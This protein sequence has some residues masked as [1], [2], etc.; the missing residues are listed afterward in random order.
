MA[1]DGLGTDAPAHADDSSVVDAASQEGIHDYFV[2]RDGQRFAGVHLLID[3]WGASGLDDAVLVER[4][5]SDA[6]AAAGATVLHVHLK[7]F[8]ENG[9]VSGVLVLAESHIS[10]H[11][12]PERGFA[13]IDIFTCGNCVPENAVPVFERAFTP[14]RVTVKEERRGVDG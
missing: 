6:A 4:T 9:G 14:E 12:W 10:I 13:A 3:L 2:T 7:Q 1:T 5:L 11:T 8:G